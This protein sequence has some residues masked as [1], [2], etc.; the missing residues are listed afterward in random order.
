[1]DSRHGVLRVVHREYRR[2]WRS[3]RYVLLLT[4][5]I[6]I[7][8]V[9][10]A[11]LTQDGMP[12][13]LPVGVVD[14]D[15]TFLSRRLCHELNTTQGVRVAAV[16]NSHTEARK[17]MQRGE[18]FA[19]YEI[20]AGTYNEVLQFHAPHFGLY[21]NT[22][23]LL[24]GNLAYKQLATLGMLAAGAVQR[25]VYRK[26]GYT[27]DQAMGLMMPAEIDAHLISNPLS[28]YSMYLMTTLIPAVIAFIVLSHMSYLIG[29]ES[30]ERTLR[31]WLRKADNNV[32]RA[33]VGKMLPYTLHYSLLLLIANVLMFGPMHFTLEG[34]WWLMVLASVLL[35]VG[36]QCAAVFICGCLPDANFAMGVTAVYGALCFSLS[37]FSFP[38]EAMPSIFTGISWLYPIRH[39]YLIYRDVAI[40]GNGLEHCWPYVCA[41]LSFALMAFVGVWMMRR[42]LQKTGVLKPAEQ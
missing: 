26:K 23:Y 21:S 4:V 39:Y 32:L 14:M 13:R 30:K 18:I 19:F 10:F 20:P 11:T 6:A 36:V 7:M 15:G 38:V 3:P 40:F 1:M 28:S 8:F 37:G 31:S 24:A 27:D 29:R 25:E 5:G 16:Y 17:A 41:L 42:N 2:I 9:F 34:S 33:V 22:A 12:Q 35:V